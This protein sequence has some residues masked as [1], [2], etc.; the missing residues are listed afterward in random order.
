MPDTSGETGEGLQESAR[1]IAA[2]AAR[3]PSGNQSRQL[4]IFLGCT[5]LVLTTVVALVAYLAIKRSEEAMAD[6]LAEKG[7]SLLKVF[8]SA[9]KTGMRGQAGLQLQPLLKEMAASPDIVFVAVTMPDGVIIAHSREEQIGEVLQFE[10]G[11]LS[12][13]RMA[14]FAPAAAE[15]WRLTEVDRQPVF[16]LYRHFTLGQTNWNPEVPEPTI[17]LGLDRSPFEITNSQNRSYV[18][19]LSVVTLLAGLACLFIISL[20]ERAAES[21]SGQKRAELEVRRL[22]QEIRRNEKL[23][24]VGTMAAG[25]AHEIRNPLSSIKG[26]ATYFQQRFPEGSEDREAAGVLVGEVNRLNKVISDLLDLARPR[27]V[28]LQPVNIQHVVAYTLRLIR[29]TAQKRNIALQCKIA[30][31][32]P[33]VLADMETLG[34]ALLNLCLNALEAMGDGGTLTIA[35][36]G[37]RARLC[38]MV[39]DTGQGIPQDTLERIFEPYFTTKGSGTGLGLPVVHRI[40]AAHKARIDVSSRVAGQTTDQGGQTVFRIWLQAVPKSRN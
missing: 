7:A 35:V 37:G 22:E 32:V 17:F 18:A 33:D 27:T 30:Q 19:M 3:E 23:A 9:L 10:D 15:Q 34:Q 13:E 40:I 4:G 12:A 39:V 25:V 31:R 8:E 38:L 5:A 24:A 26:Y 2:S 28:K 16:L 14:E 29:Q 6:L 20:A 21:R 11:P 1:K 36:S